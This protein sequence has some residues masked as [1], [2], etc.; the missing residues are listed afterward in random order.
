MHEFKAKFINGGD[1]F[2]PQKLVI[3]NKQVIWTER[4]NIFYMEERNITLNRNTI[5]S[6][7][8]NNLLVGCELTIKSNGGDIIH[9]KGLDKSDGKLISNILSR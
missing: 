8:V 2:F 7:H 5:N 9:M 3:T 1:P 6:I 4:H